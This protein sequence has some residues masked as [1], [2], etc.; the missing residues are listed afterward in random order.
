MMSELMG[1]KTG[2]EGLAFLLLAPGG[3]NVGGN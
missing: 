2:G 1:S 3:Y